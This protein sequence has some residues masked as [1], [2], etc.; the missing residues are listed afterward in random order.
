MQEMLQLKGK[1]KTGEKEVNKEKIRSCSDRKSATS[2]I[3]M[4]VVFQEGAVL[5]RNTGKSLSD[6]LSYK[7]ACYTAPWH[8]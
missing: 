7:N 6:M 1:Y 4:D 3:L 2:K 8:M 5:F